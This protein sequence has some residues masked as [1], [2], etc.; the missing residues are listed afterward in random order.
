MPPQYSNMA[1]IQRLRSLQA[2]GIETFEAAQA[3][4]PTPM[5]TNG[6]LLW[7]DDDE[8]YDGPFVVDP[9]RPL[10]RG[11]SEDLAERQAA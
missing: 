10:L 11:F 3:C 7:D 6:E 8:N 5:T 2:E 4:C 1:I 9:F